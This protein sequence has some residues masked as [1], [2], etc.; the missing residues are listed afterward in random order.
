MERFWRAALGVAGI[1]AIAFFVFLSLYTGFLKLEIFS[2]ISSQQTFI[3]ML[4]FLLLTFAA[5]VIGVWAKMR[6][7]PAEPPEREDAAL[8]RLESAWVGVN[9]IDCKR[10]VGPDVAKAGNA[11]HMTS[12]Y[13]RNQYIARATLSEKFGLQFCELYEQLDACKKAVPGY[14]APVKY[15]GDFLPALVRSTYA[16][17]SKIVQR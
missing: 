1:G 14:T 5:L 9:Y 7:G 13:W 6:S 11:L 10:L 8:Y 2:Q 3:L 17:I 16:E 12:L 15:C 4:A